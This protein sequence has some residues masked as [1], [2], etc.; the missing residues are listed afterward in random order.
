M[1]FTSLGSTHN[2]FNFTPTQHHL[3]SLVPSVTSIMLVRTYRCLIF[4]GLLNQWV[5]MV[6]MSSNPVSKH[7]TQS[8][9]LIREHVNT[10]QNLELQP[11]QCK[12]DPTPAVSSPW[13]LNLSVHA[14]AILSPVPLRPKV[15]WIHVQKIVV[16]RPAH[17]SARRYTPWMC[18]D[19]YWL[20]RLHM[21]LKIWNGDDWRRREKRPWRFAEKQGA[22]SRPD[23]T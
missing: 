21:A 1:P 11:V 2:R 6:R 10:W 4:R 22:L 16:V 23:F 14:H 19:R 3:T 20:A 8:P 9:Q 12:H 18:K 15:G 5:M 17:R 7:A 13:I